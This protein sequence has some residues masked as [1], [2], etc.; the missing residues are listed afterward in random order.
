MKSTRI[1][2]KTLLI[3][4]GL[5]WALGT[6]AQ[7]PL[8]LG[9]A[10][11][12]AMTNHAEVQRAAL[13]IQK[14]RELV[15][16]SVATG[17]PQVGVQ[18]QMVYNPSLRTSLVP[19]EFFGGKP[20][21]F[22]SIQFGTSWNGASSI[23]LDQ[24][25]FNKTWL[26]GVRASYAVTDF[27][28][29][30]YDKSK[31]DVAYEVA[32]L[33]YQALFARSQRGLL[34]ANLEQ[35]EGLLNT[36]TRQREQGFATQIDVERLQVQRFNLQTELNNLELQIG[37]IDQALK[38]AMNMPLDAEII[39]ADTLSEAPFDNVSMVQ[40]QPSYTQKT[41]LT[42]LKQQM[43]L[44][45]LDE[46]R[47]QAGYFPSLSFFATYNYEWQANKLDDFGNGRYWSDFSQIGV[48]LVAPIFDGFYKDSKRQTALLNKQQVGLQYDRALKGLQ[49]QH[50]TAMSTLRTQQ[51]RLQSLRENIALAQKVYDVAKQRYQQG[52]GNIVEVL[53][54]ETSLRSAQANYLGV[55][56]QLKMAEIDLLHAN[57]KLIEL[58]R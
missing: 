26:L 39:L 19:A 46:R 29:L 30:L 36:I 4:L 13:E 11:D 16:E 45:D 20:G 33:Y 50:Q 8:T 58:A 43:K 53:E 41:D 37:Q 18:A 31:E 35:V 42:V 15:R 25:L 51:N 5:S 17:L 2:P 24:M 57:G 12:Y 14:G 40:A 28:Q 48:R 22:Q 27:Y 21:E 9:A 23:Y 38:F 55:L 54:A 47:W 49:L 6:L 52:L 44:Y 32:K 1:H 34:E 56:A 7:T 10:M 3:A